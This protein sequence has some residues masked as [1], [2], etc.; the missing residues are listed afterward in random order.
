MPVA[1]LPPAPARTVAPAVPV[2]R[3]LPAPAEVAAVAVPAALTLA[4]GLWGIRRQDTLW[5][6]EAVTYAMAQRDLTR[7]WHTAQHVDLV[8]ALYYAVMHEVFAV[9]G[10]GLLTLRLPSVLAM[11][12]AAAGV[13]LLG[14]RLAGPRAGLLAGVVFAVLPQVQKYAQEGRSYA[15]VCALVAWAGPA[16]LAGAA[17]PARWRWAVYGSVMLAACL[18]HEFAVLALA[19]HGVTL[20]VA[21]VPRPVLRAWGVTAAGVAAGLSPL[22]VLSAGQSAQVSW[23]EGPVR[24]PG[25]LAVTVLGVVCARPSL[26]ARGP[27]RL[28]SLALPLLV[29]PGLLLLIASL[30]RPIFVDRYVLYSGVGGALLLGAWADAVLRGRRCHRAGWVAA[31][32]VLAALVPPS[33]ALRTPQSRSNDATAVGAAVREAGRPGDGL[34]FLPGRHR[35]LT[36]AAPRDT[37]ALTDLALARDPVSSDTLAGAELPARDIPA[38]MREFDRIVAVRVTDARARTDPRELAKT[39]TLRRH[40]HPE[41]TTRVHGA[42]VTVYVRD[43]DA[44][45]RG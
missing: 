17:R 18:L 36:A 41:S 40:F 22:V 3:R 26:G 20:A 21:R 2:R 24:L 6:D 31:A 32:V 10:G 25:V 1:H 28:W 9:L 27:V 38:R 4:L 30:V 37:R 19:A 14:L 7:I 33:L 12:A 11:S 42:R 44:G 35:V 8:H 43:D 15:L 34:L 5:G 13:G 16:L 39:D 23:I 45:A 29:L